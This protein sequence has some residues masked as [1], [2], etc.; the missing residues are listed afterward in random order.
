MYPIDVKGDGVRPRIAIP[1]WRR[2]LPTMLGERT[3]LD[4]LDPAY[5]GRVAEAGGLPLILPRPPA[6]EAAE[7][8]AESLE[9]VDGLLLSGGGDLDPRSYRAGGERGAIDA[10]LE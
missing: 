9:L 7:V 3:V 6:A 1:P 8:A 5:S 2:E 10:D 4:A